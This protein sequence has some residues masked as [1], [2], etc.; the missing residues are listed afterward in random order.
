MGPVAS[1]SWPADCGVAPFC[2]RRDMKKMNSYRKYMTAC[3]VAE[4][5]PPHAHAE[6]KPSDLDGFRELHEAF[7]IARQGP[8]P[9]AQMDGLGDAGADAHACYA[10]GVP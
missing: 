4:D 2:L 10:F 8:R 6:V 3:H 1:G 5:L 9:I 7:E